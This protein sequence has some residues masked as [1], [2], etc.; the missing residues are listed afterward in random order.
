MTTGQTAH[1]LRHHL[2]AVIKVGGRSTTHS[3][4]FMGNSAALSAT[5]RA[6]L[7]VFAVHSRPNFEL[8]WQRR[9]ETSSKSS[10]FAVQTESGAR[11]L[12]TNAH[13]VSY[14]TEVQVKRRGDDQ[15]Y[16]AR[17]LAVGTECDVALLTGARG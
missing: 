5:G 6:N 1:L 12:L 11:W 3:H 8:P 16:L 2:D 15:K 4:E 17:V 7:Q 13:S 10:G 9:K 14:A